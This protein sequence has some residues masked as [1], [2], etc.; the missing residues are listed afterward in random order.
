MHALIRSTRAVDLGDEDE[1]GAVLDDFEGRLL[2][3]V[4]SVPVS[5]VPAFSDSASS[6]RPILSSG[7]LGLQCRRLL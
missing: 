2:D 1:I 6:L 3:S 7:A 5:S 4:G